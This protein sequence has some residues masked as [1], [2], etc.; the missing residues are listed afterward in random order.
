MIAVLI[1][2][3]AQKCRNFLPLPINEGKWGVRCELGNWGKEMYR[4][5]LCCYSKHSSRY[6]CT[7]VVVSGSA[8]QGLVS[9]GGEWR[10]V[11]CRPMCPCSGWLVGIWHYLD[12]PCHREIEF[13]YCSFVT[14]GKPHVRRFA[15]FLANSFSVDTCCSKSSAKWWVIV[16]VKRKNLKTFLRTNVL[17]A[18]YRTILFSLHNA[19]ALVA[20]NCMVSSKLIRIILYASFTGTQKSKYVKNQLLA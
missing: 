18:T 5:N 9:F 6:Q 17:S 11:L 10:P 1:S 14:Q 15:S 4:C 20:F 12:L 19:L 7:V 3:I 13:P 2:E 16:L 8:L